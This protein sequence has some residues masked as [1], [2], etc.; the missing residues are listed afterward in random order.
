MRKRFT[1]KPVPTLLAASKSNP[2]G[3]TDL[4][5]SVASASA[6]ENTLGSALPW[7]IA[8]LMIA[9]IGAVAVLM[10]RSRLIAQSHLRGGED[11]TVTLLITIPR[12]RNQ[13]DAKQTDAAA[14]IKE[15]IAVA[16][17]LYSAIGGLKPHHG[18]VA[19]FMGRSDAIAF[20]IVA[21]KKLVSFYMT[22]PKGMRQ[23]AEQQL[24]AQWSDAQFEEVMDYNM[25]A[26]QSTILG[27]Y[28]TLKRK[29]V[30]P[31][32]TYKEQ[33]SDPLNAITNAL[34]KV[35]D[36]D[37]VAIQYVIRSAP[38][39]WREAGQKIAHAMYEGKKLHEAEHGHSVLG[40]LGEWTQSKEDRE[41]AEAKK[42][43]RK[44]T[45]A[46][47]KL[48]EGI[49][50][51]ISKA[52]MEVNIRIVAS[53]SSPDIAQAHLNNVLSAFNQ[54]NIYEYG[55]SFTATI[56]RSKD[57]LVKDFIYRRFS[58]K[59]SIILNTEEMS[60]VW[61]LPLP[62]TETPNIR[63]MMARTAPAPINMPT[64]GLRIGTNKYRGKETTVFMGDQDRRRHLYIIGKTGSGKSEFI[65][66]MVA[67]DIANGHGVAVIDPHGDLADGCLELVPK[68]RIDDV[69]Y[70]NPSDTERPFGLNMMEFDANFPEQKTF[71]VNEMLAIFDQLYDLKATGGPMFEQYM[72]NAMLLLMDDV[73]S[74]ATLL[75]ISKVLSDE[76]YRKAKLDKC[77]NR[78]VVDF[79]TKEAQK[80]GGEASL[81][82]MVPY[83]TS[84][85]TTFISNDI[86]RPIITQ[87][88]S[89]I[90]F[91]NI[92][93]TKKILLVNLSKGKLGDINAALIGMIVVSKLQ[94]AAFAQGDTAEKDRKDLYLYIDEFQNFITPSI[95]TIL[96]E[97]RKY[98]L[99]LIMAHQYM[100]QLVKN[101]DTKIRDAVLG[102]VGSYMVARV[103]PDD[104]EVL[105]KV[106]EPT[107][108][109]YDLMNTTAQMW[110]AKIIINGAQEKP[111]TLI[112]DPMVK[113]SKE[114]ADGL[115]QISRLMYGRDREE[116]EEETYRRSGMSAL[117][118]AKAPEVPTGF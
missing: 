100:G 23:F 97:A 15:Q 31:I 116:V 68:D 69:V 35:V 22:V 8:F 27:G 14:A 92:I 106:F 53:G 21:H 72:R 57:T 13:E 98:R 40:S 118:S 90:N 10:I 49:E 18:F 71:V 115:K 41:K 38:H 32:K 64:A 75:E 86:M 81:A 56:P 25:F 78:V 80:A 5:P 30:F 89:S 19:W 34:S 111:F 17:S 50:N 1:P 74:G 44:L 95:A 101:G 28:L 87:Q 108:S 55:N 93:D 36:S 73:S 110:S 114:M 12:F 84:K 47:Q 104:T 6:V 48:V 4:T 96:S 42:K 91:R 113:G 65:K 99:N 103:G 33:E 16:E 39:G 67:Q 79:W 2:Y 3:I 45:Q 59:H 85:L 61:H 109:A 88:E 105:E 107:F 60:S 83:I 26:P 63:W 117:K 62:S 24:H 37:G 9:G 29:S 70:F 112:A 66:N 7:V 51:K 46:E 52:G 58:E 11:S 94:L 43:D 76:D 54:F 102:N 77:T 82:N 20:E